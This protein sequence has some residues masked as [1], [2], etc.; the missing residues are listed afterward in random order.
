MN[1]QELAH[2]ARANDR[3]VVARV[4]LLQG[5][6][7]LHELRLLWPRSRQ[8]VAVVGVLGPVP[9]HAVVKPQRTDARV[10]PARWA[11]G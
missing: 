8:P 2:V 6:V 7:L 9:E 4:E 1:R 3:Q 10:H 5:A 11:G